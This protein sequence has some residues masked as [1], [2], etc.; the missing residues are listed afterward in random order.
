MPSR[1]DEQDHQLEAVSSFSDLFD[2][3]FTED[4][5]KRS[6][7][8][9]A[10]LTNLQNVQKRNGLVAD[11][12]L[13]L[14]TAT[15]FDD[16]AYSFPNFSA[17][18]ETATGKTY[19]YIRTA[20]TLAKRHGLRQFVIVVPS[21][22]IREGTDAAFKATAPHFSNHPD[23]SDVQ[24][25]WNT[26]R[27]DQPHLID[28]FTIPSNKVRFLITTLAAF[29][30][31]DENRIYRESESLHLFSDGTSGS[32][33]EKLQAV[34]PVLI[35]DE[36]QNMES[37]LSKRALATLRPLLALRY[38]A[39][40]EN[41]YNLVYRLGPVEAREKNLVKRVAVRGV[42]AVV[43][44]LGAPVTCIE[45][46]V[47]R[48]AATAR[49]SVVKA[50]V[51]GTLVSRER[52]V[53]PGDDLADLTGRENYDGYVIDQIK[54]DG[55]LFDNGEFAELGTD[56]RQARES[57]WRD[58]LAHTLR[59]HFERQ[60]DLVGR[61]LDV[62]VLSLFFIEK[63][64]DYVSVDAPL[65]RIFR[66][67]Y[68]RLRTRFPEHTSANPADV[69][70]AYFSKTARGK[71]QDETKSEDDER[72]AIDLILRDK[73]KL[74][75]KDEPT[76]FIFSHTALSEGW[77]NPNVFQICFLRHS[78]STV[79]RRQQVGR[80]LRLPLTQGG[81]RVF[82]KDVNRLTLVVNESYEDFVAKL[83]A[84]YGH[85]AAAGESGGGGGSGSGN[86]GKNGP[87]PI[88]DDAAK[89]RVT[90]KPGKRDT[91]EFKELWSRIRYRTNYH[92]SL[93]GDALVSA[94][95]SADWDVLDAI[96]AS[97]NLV[98]EAT[99]GTDKKGAFSLGD[100]VALRGVQSSSAALPDLV[101]LIERALHDR[102]PR[103]TLTRRTIAAAL[104]A[105]PKASQRSSVFAPERWAAVFASQVK[106]AAA[107]IMVKHIRYELRPESDWWDAEVILKNSY[108]A[109]Q[110]KD[111]PNRGYLE[112][113]SPKSPNYYSHVD[114]D[115]SSEKAF[116]QALETSGA[117]VRLYVRLPR[118]FDVPTPVGTF[119]PDYAV[120]A[121]RED[122]TE[123]VYL[124]QEVKSTL[125][126]GERRRSENQKIRF[127]RKHFATAPKSVH[128]AVTTGEQGL[129]LDE[130]ED[131]A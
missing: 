7:N 104:R 64:A 99:L 22:A 131:D 55:V 115:S 20:L 92:V 127:A 85:D 114:Y 17:D 101:G 47:R 51:D 2:Q 130:Q 54:Q 97:S 25:D 21:V 35:L 12:A 32:Q 46:T 67:E 102:E 4:D 113:S 126:E 13:A 100:E 75:S 98:R 27:S 5:G 116:A 41:V 82:D 78:R 48:K 96:R 94:L 123:E 19:A 6:L 128:F 52:T 122:S 74:L 73:D 77:D 124:V 103:L 86:N 121:V 110:S 9:K 106:A 24:Y 49:L 50:L 68:E 83:N 88:D 90:V 14:V 120:V 95:S 62:K 44:P 45:T 11:S 8:D 87:P 40:H 129:R 37:D 53:E 33:M 23:F 28:D 117:Q 84:E 3:A 15:T 107:D 58:Q 56:D 57:V 91:A 38:S 119:S 18:M 111:D 29:N 36:P 70:G 60:S 81:T 31:K 30:R 39:S 66:E 34:R 69:R 108:D 43:D 93:D 109:F 76:A 105:V 71:W 16:V 10:V 65:P 26:Y 89:V 1:F 112:T 118:S 79:Q 61:G 42:S 125:L 72:R 80:G 59:L 63:V